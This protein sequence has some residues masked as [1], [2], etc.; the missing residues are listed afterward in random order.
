MNERE[1]ALEVL[2]QIV[3]EGEFSHIALRQVLAQYQY[4]EK[5]KRAFLTKVVE[6]TLERMI[7]LDHVINCFSKTSTDRMKPEIL[8]ILRSGVYQLFYMDSVPDSA[9][10]NEAVKLAKRKGFAPL[11]GFVNGVLRNIAR[12]RK[13]IPYPDKKEIKKYISVRYSLPEWLVDQWVKEYGAEVTEQMGQEFL[14]EQP[15]T[16]HIHTDRIDRQALIALLEQEG[17]CVRQDD[18]YADVLY[19]SEYD[20]LGKVSGF[21]KGYFQVQDISSMEVVRLAEPKEGD[22]VLD[23]CA[24][25][26]GKAVHMAQQLHGTGQVEAR[27]LTDY[28]IEQLEENRIRNGLSN[29]TVKKWDARILDEAAVGQKDIVLADLPCSGLGVLG[30]KPDLKYKMTRDMTKSLCALQKEILEVVRQYVKPGGKLV[31]STCTINREENE[32]N[33]RWFLE[34]FPEFELRKQ[35]QR[36][37]GIHKGDGFYLAVFRKCTEA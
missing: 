4:L 17:V 28:K 25:P 10:C 33:T 18:T 26:G 12:H 20:Y 24:A 36:L 34:R 27:D 37:P 8:L 9:V 15:L 5:R 21:Q 19:L 13:E 22:Q 2:L 3:K 35:E 1:L 14:K 30:R 7:E 29:M 31:Y 6:G 32:E 16:V 11:A 23:V